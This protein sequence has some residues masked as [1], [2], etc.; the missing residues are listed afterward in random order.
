MTIFSAENYKPNRKIIC[1]RQKSIFLVT[2]I[3]F[4]K[5]NIN[6]EQEHLNNKKNE[7]YNK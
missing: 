3:K 5:A 7:L 4:R 1:L 2:I 6:I